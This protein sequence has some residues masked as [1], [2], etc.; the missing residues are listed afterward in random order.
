M[1]KT[2]QWKI[3]MPQGGKRKE[4]ASQRKKPYKMKPTTKLFCNWCGEEAEKTIE[5]MC[6]TCHKKWGG[7]VKVAEKSEG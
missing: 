2:S 3:G 6:P 1:Q 5:G 4:G 7:R